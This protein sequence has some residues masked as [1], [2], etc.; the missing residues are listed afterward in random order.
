[1]GG[2]PGRTMRSVSLEEEI[3]RSSVEQT[4]TNLMPC[5]GEKVAKLGTRR[6]RDRCI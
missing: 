2:T 1:M 3:S 5:V 6:K 4:R